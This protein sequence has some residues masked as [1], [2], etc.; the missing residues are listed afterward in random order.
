MPHDSAA[1]YL[2]YQQAEQQLLDDAGII[3]LDWGKANVLIRPSVHGLL[4]N[5][6]GGLGAPNW[7]AVTVS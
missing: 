7:A 4:L 2:K 5:G 1:R 3:V 6:L